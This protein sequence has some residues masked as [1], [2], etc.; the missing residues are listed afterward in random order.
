VVFQ[1]AAKTK[2][3]EVMSGF[4]AAAQLAEK[5]QDA[6]GVG[7]PPQMPAEFEQQ[8]HFLARD[9]ILEAKQLINDLRGAS[10]VALGV[11]SRNFILTSGSS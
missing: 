8:I 1:P 7:A 3:S 2:E 9:R 10:Q 6:L 11:H 4:H 5:A